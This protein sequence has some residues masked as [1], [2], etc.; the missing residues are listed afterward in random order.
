V[1]PDQFWIQR[2]GSSP[3]VSLSPGERS[4][5]REE[6]AETPAKSGSSRKTAPSGLSERRIAAVIIA[7]AALLACIHLRNASI[8]YDEAIT[9]LT[10][11]GHAQVD[12]SLGVMQFHPTANLGKILLDLRNQD[13]HPPLYFWALAIWRVLFGASLE[14]ARSFS[15]CFVFATLALLFRVAQQLGV[16]PA[17]VPVA[18]YATSSAGTWYAYDARPYAMATFLIVLTQF[19]AYRKSRWAG[20][21]ATAGVA[22]HYFAALC[23]GP[24]LA[25]ECLK[26]RR[27]DR[28]WV[29]WTLFSFGFCSAP[30]VWLLKIHVA[31]RPN[32]YA[33]FG[34]LL[35]EVWALLKGSMQ[36][37]LPNTSLPG[38][39]LAVIAGGFFVCAGL[40]S[41]IKK[42]KWA[43]PLFYGAFLC[44][45]LLLAV[46]T[47]KSM[48]QMPSAYYLGIAAPWLAL[49][50][51]YGV[52]AFPRVSPLLAMIVVVGLFTASPIV[53]TVDYR[54][55]VSKM[56]AE[57]NHCAIIAGAGF[58]GA[59]PACVLY[60]ARGMPVFLL[61]PGDSVGEVVQRVGGRGMIFFV[62]TNEPPT[63]AVEREFLREY[64]S[65]RRNGYF[66]VSLGRT[67][68]M[69]RA[70][71]SY[72]GSV[73]VLSAF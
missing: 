10:T 36:G 40:W 51:G 33:G 62:P 28:G 66:E 20:V 29:A 18:L 21:C 64:L 58:A 67:P 71:H 38:W 50:V 65:T 72:D 68:A 34:A 8:W 25:L 26:R 31:A 14:V 55:M 54:H 4:E 73:P 6:A 52:R 45:F 32:Q 37:A 1:E 60:E 27:T 46:V 42:G 22:T 12:W 39:G 61:R 69:E 59:V 2:G 13:V 43:V 5:L 3:V 56:R 49:L 48:V 24:V 11:S 9:L 47:D 41:T 15:A 7:C 19:L 30:L 53:R 63:A 57:C 17:W 70:S 44:S 23:V 35:Q 16:R